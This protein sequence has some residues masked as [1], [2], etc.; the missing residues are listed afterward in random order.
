MKCPRQFSPAAVL[1]YRILSP[2]SKTCKTE[3]QRITR[4]RLSPSSRKE[5]PQG[6]K[7]Q[8]TCFAKYFVSVAMPADFRYEKKFE[9]VLEIAF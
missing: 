4:I 3:A 6:E 2:K 1:V 7:P 5:T 9:V 8:S